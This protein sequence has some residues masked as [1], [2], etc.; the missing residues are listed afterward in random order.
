M[1]AVVVIEGGDGEDGDGAGGRCRIRTVGTYRLGSRLFRYWCCAL[2]Q[3]QCT[4][5]RTARWYAQIRSLSYDQ[6]H[7]IGSGQGACC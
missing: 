4:V 3:C 1:V 6:L 2:S 7:K 5:K